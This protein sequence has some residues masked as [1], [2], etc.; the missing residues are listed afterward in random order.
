MRD[1]MILYPSARM[2][3]ISSWLP[4]CVHVEMIFEVT[5]IVSHTVNFDS[6]YK[7]SVYSCRG[8]LSAR[9]EFF[10]KC[11]SLVSAGALAAVTKRSSSYEVVDCESCRR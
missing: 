9:N 6:G 3:F 8:V 11:S 7:K 1:V 5:F 10:E 4:G 2:Y